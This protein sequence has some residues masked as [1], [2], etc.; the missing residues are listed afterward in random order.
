M[1]DFN[2][3]RRLF[4]KGATASLALTAFGEAEG[5]DLI[6]PQKTLR[7]ALIGTGWYG[8]SDLFR[9]I[10]VAPV[11]VV[12][13]CDVDKNQLSKAGTLVSKRQKSV[14]S[15]GVKVI[16]TGWNAKIDLFRLLQVA[17][18]EVKQI[19]LAIPSRANQCYP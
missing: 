14:K 10:Q 19:S 9:L 17:P 18:V 5:M 15:D 12:A 13:L 4:L 1:E 8:K 7:V 2:I 16:G 3:N 11:E 6:Y